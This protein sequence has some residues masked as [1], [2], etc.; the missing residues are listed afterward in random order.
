METI[1]TGL[2]IWFRTFLVDY[3]AAL[4]KGLLDGAGAPLGIVEPL[5]LTKEEVDR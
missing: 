1:F 3:G 5:A 4:G 2:V